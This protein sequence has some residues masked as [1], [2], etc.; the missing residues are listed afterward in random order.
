M[1]RGAMLDLPVLPPAG[2]ADRVARAAARRRS[3]ITRP[4]PSGPMSFAGT[5]PA[6]AALGLPEHATLVDL[7]EAIRALPYARNEDRTAD[8]VL[9]ERRGTCSTKHALL[10]RLIAQRWP[11]L[12]PRLVHRVYRVQ[13][14]DARRV[15]G[16]HA[17]AAAPP[18][19]LVDVHRYLTVRI[20]GREVAVDATFPGTPR[21]DGETP[22]RL[23]CG[24]GVDHPV[25]SG[26][27][28]GEKH[29][30][31]LAHCDPAVREPFIAA[32]AE[33]RR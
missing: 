18:D 22:M 7:V 2:D 25:V 11:E 5:D 4:V 13:P 24:R 19:G 15:F 32:L 8:G 1:T 26:D 6:L 29:V 12:C 3:L 17:A 23:A 20:G 30:L 16:A 9:A 21:W 27:P 10:H 31:E 14:D 33:A 28:A